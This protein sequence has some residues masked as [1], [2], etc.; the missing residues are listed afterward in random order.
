MPK[1]T[2]T[3]LIWN[4]SKSNQMIL[5]NPMF[6][7]TDDMTL[8]ADH[9]VTVWMIWKNKLTLNQASLIL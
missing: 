8:S 7:F 2:Y 5:H 9:Q 6:P 3:Y 4:K 1:L